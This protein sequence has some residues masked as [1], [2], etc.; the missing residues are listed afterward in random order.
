MTNTRSK[1]RLTKKRSRDLDALLNEI[2]QNLCLSKA[3]SADGRVDRAIDY[4]R[5]LV[6][7]KLKGGRD[8]DTESRR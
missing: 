7:W 4:V 2:E 6:D 3:A 5:R 1:P 8:A